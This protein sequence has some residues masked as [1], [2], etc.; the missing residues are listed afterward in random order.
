M[1]VQA[2]KEVHVSESGELVGAD[3]GQPVAVDPIMDFQI[4]LSYELP[5]LP[6]AYLANVASLEF[7]YVDANNVVLPAAYQIHG[8]RK[9]AEGRATFLTAVGDTITVD[10]SNGAAF[11]ESD[12][13]SHM[14]I[15]DDG[16]S[17]T[18]KAYRDLPQL[19]DPHDD[20]YTA[21]KIKWVPFT[22]IDGGW[23][24]PDYSTSK[25]DQ[26][27]RNARVIVEKGFQDSPYVPLGSLSCKLLT[28]K[29][30]VG[31]RQ[32]SRILTEMP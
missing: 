14:I 18:N 17:A 12:G 19:D 6:M 27:A 8:V 15:V 26:Y 9:T 21:R 22:T 24:R 11:L 31:Y 23:S 25:K 10:G 7:Q 16:R 4:N 2:S 5:F 29:Y 32:S 20:V 30:L 1:A 13:V 28:G 3:T